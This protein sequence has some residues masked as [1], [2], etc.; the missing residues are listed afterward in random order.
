[1]SAALELGGRVAALRQARGYTQEELGALLNVTSQAVS[2]WETGKALPDI[3]LLPPLARALRTSIDRLLL[4]RDGAQARGPYDEAYAQAAFYWGQEP[5][6]LAKE[7]AAL[8]TAAQRPA[9]RVLDI[10]SGEGRDAVY[11]ARCG[12]QVDALEISAPGI[13]KIRRFSAAAKCDVRVL[14]ADML[15]FVLTGA[16]DLVYSMGSLQFLPPEKRREA[17]AAYKEH[18]LPGGFNAHLAFVEKPFVVPAPDW[19]REERFYRSG[20]LA[21]YYWDWEILCGEEQLLDCCS[22]GTPHRH[23]VCTLLARKPQAQ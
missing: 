20:E 1:M 19:E 8:L 7:A 13:E 14:H 4:G 3:A 5:S 16:Y 17:F 18:T 21:G 2:K 11:F 12:F 15:D 23:A 22:S 6:A 10:G 9:A